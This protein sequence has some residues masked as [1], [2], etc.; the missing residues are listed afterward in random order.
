MTYA[1]LQQSLDQT[2]SR[3][4]LEEA[5]MVAPRVARAD[6]ALLQRELFGIVV[7][8]LPHAEASA[9]Q[10]A[11]RARNFS[12]DIVAESA[13][14]VLPV[15]RGAPALK[16]S[17]AGVTV[18]D[19][20]G[21]EQ[22]LAPDQY[23]FA[24]AGRVK[25]LRNVPAREME[26]T[27]QPGPRGSVSRKVEMVKASRLADVLEFR[28]ELFLTGEPYRLQ[29]VLDGESTLRADDVVLQLKHGVQ[30]NHLLA[31]IA[32]LLPVERV[33]QG[34]QRAIAGEEFVYPSVRAFEEE[35]IWRFYRLLA[36]TAF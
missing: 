22:L 1:L 19:L 14:P 30:L 10:A 16:V 12:T 18:V 3:S 2:I 24:A 15:A 28:I 21:R 32:A 17:P 4:D 26:W 29:W 27:V 7:G 6:C 8:K 23:V 9:L 13:L 25:R 5:S 36:G 31:R 35:I 20:Y 34:I 11:L 33:N